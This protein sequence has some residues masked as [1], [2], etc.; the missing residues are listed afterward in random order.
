M[1]IMGIMG[2]IGIMVIRGIIGIMGIMGITGVM[3]INPHLEIVIILGYGCT[4]QNKTVRMYPLRVFRGGPPPT[5]TPVAS[6]HC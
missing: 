6:H 1:R 4:I 3:G 2:I 5:P